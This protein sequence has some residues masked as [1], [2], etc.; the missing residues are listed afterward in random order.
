M[1]GL[2]VTGTDTGAGKSY[3][4][5]SIA[6]A[7]TARGEQLLV[8]KPL[9][10][11]MDDPSEGLRD[12]ELLALAI[13]SSST[14]GISTRK[15]GPAVSPHLA[16]AE[17]GVQLDAAEIAAELLAETKAG[18]SL[19]VEGVGGLL[20]PISQT[21]S[22]RDLA[23]ALGLAVVVAA[24]PGLGTISHTLLTVESARAVGLEVKLIVFG[25]WSDSPTALEL[26]NRATVA[27]IS[28][29]E[30]A[31]IPEISEPSQA[32]FAE[33]GSGLPIDSLLPSR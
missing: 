20:V 18:G 15:F 22:V 31:T 1:R 27:R 10:T 17:A 28:G 26:D 14:A 33:A 21:E 8:R 5:A 2:F 23:T 7:L 30:V 29:I 12:D 11:G 19:L 9:L 4:T 16:A 24:R 6:A 32:A 3:V 13:G 25:P